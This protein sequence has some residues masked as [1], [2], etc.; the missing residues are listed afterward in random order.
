MSY[1]GSLLFSFNAKLLDFF[2]H[3]GMSTDGAKALGGKLTGI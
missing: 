3:V 1:V 2:H